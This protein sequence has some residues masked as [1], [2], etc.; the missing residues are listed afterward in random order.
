VLLSDLTPS[1]YSRLSKLL[2][3]S[4]D[5]PPEEREAW[6][7]KLAQCEPGLAETLRVVFGSEGTDA[8]GALRGRLDLLAGELAAALKTDEALVGRR[9][10][11]Y[12]VIS[13]LGHGGMGS[14]W[15]AERA[16]GL[17]TRQVALKLVQPGLMGRVMT[18]RLARER[19]I[20]ASLDHP[21]IARLLDAGFAE[22]GQPYL[23]LEYV[24]GTPLTTF[25]DDHRLSIGERLELF[26][27]ALRAVQYAHAHLVIHRDLKPSNILVTPEG[28][29]QLLDFGI[30]KLISEG[31]AKETQLT[32]LGGRAMTVDYAAPEQ[33]AGVPLSTAADV[34]GLGV[35]LYELLTGQRPY[36]PKRDT[37]G[38]LEEAILSADPV[39]PSRLDLSGEVAQARETTAKKLSSLLKGDLDTIVMK[40]LKKSPAERYPTVAAFDEDIARFL[41]GDVVLAQPDRATYRA[42]KF[43]RR[44]WVGLAVAASLILTLA[45]GLAVATYEA[46]VAAT[47]RNAALQARNVALQAQLRSLTQTAAA[48]IHEG[49]VASA[50]GIALELLPGAGSTRRYT[51]EA[52]NVFQEA[53]AAD[54]QVLVIPTH[55]DIVWFASFSPDG[56]RIVTALNDNTAR[57]WDTASGRE[58]L[59]LTGHTDRTWS[60]VFSPDGKRIL[61][62]S[63]DNTARVWDA[64]TG[65]ELLRI[66]G[67]AGRVQR[68]T[69]SPD[70]RRV[71]TPSADG[72]AGIWDAE[73]GRELLRLRGHSDHL[74]A[75]VYS[76][77]GRQI[78]TASAD[79]TARIWDAESGRVIV[80]L[81]GHT[82]RVASVAYSPDGRYIVTASDDATARI[83]DASSAREVLRLVHPAT[84]QSAAFSP[85]G[86]RVVTAS[87]DSTARIWDAVAG[88][89]LEL[90]GGH[91]FRVNSAAFSPDGKSIVTASDDGTIRLWRSNPTPAVMQLEGHT[92]WVTRAVYSPDGARI[93]TASGDKTA[94]VWDAASGRETL[95]LVGHTDRLWDAQFSADGRRIVTGSVDRSARIWDAA[96][97]RE[98]ARLIGHSGWVNSAVFSHDGLR[99]LTASQDKSARIWDIATLRQLA[100]LEYSSPISSA[101]FS[102]D[103][104]RV[105]TSS[106]DGTARI[107]DAAT[108]RVLVTLRGH[109]D[110]VWCAHFSSDGRR[111][112]TASNDHTARIWDTNGH[113]LQRLQGHERN[114]N[115][116]AFSPDG[117][118]VATASEDETVRLWDVA[119]GDQL[120]V[121][122]THVG[123]VV[124]VAFAPDGQ[125]IVTGSLDHTARVLDTQTASLDAQV[126]W[127]AAA[128][129]DPLS[130]D[131]RFQLG[132]PPRADLR[133]WPASPTKCDEAAAAPHDPERRAPG[134]SLGRIA[135]D[136]AM[137][138]CAGNEGST[139]DDGRTLYQRGRAQMASGKVVAA[140]G[141]FEQALERHYPAAGVELA[142]LFS[143]SS[144]GMLDLRRAVSLYE[145]A[146]KDHLTIAGFEL[147]RLYERGVRDDAH[148]HSSPYVL[149]PDETRAWG[150][151]QLAADAGDPNALSRFAKR[152]DDLAYASTDAAQ[153]RLHLL[154]SFHF[155]AAAAERARMEDWPD[156]TWR[157]WRY[158]RASLARVLALAGMM[159]EVAEDYARVRARY[160][161]VRTG[162][163]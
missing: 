41:R 136:L 87:T 91:V 52:L 57:V 101:A 81:N 154:A 28:Q 119:N 84:V 39:S 142:Q 77:D 134:V 74:Y 116:A 79:G 138:A 158:R 47:Q 86:R 121:L 32:Q 111:V 67:H 104:R 133:S 160:A 59:Q 114:L 25:C 141:S 93:L 113:E 102:P 153:R 127:A 72:T 109:T 48:R 140:R 31:E 49:D 73:T 139:Q 29:V 42:L 110:I 55:T 132:L 56:R 14:V 15:L 94:R 108:H 120:A 20:L 145:L 24:S 71:V 44:H 13:L 63:S 85:D 58:L 118:R 163:G 23:A 46:R 30:A 66:A 68:A 88:T 43:V 130:R 90:L 6:L 151:Y 51:P 54:A 105:L 137:A 131:Q 106:E 103:D 22:D 148:D 40:A 143:Q 61:T 115:W 78:A 53:R 19:E 135:P 150:W 83:W 5:L 4:L 9:F 26:R 157:D 123:N 27:Q 8:S 161:S 80:A 16:D 7:G 82:S 112:V 10:G 64:A 159:Q 75:A 11:A 97:G 69:F 21:N 35:T 149:V 17:F 34:Y 45:V 1:Q 96:N 144:Y 65:R 156:D 122:G 99:V 155:Y 100:R 117:T 38:A 125:R 60:A 76:P 146:F 36:R 107:W 2:D 95:R 62:G 92:D 152:E 129:L 70:G 33:I 98:L 37:R 89:Q 3:E 12:R 126:E 162:P 128:Q 18:E 147:G 50:M 124:Y